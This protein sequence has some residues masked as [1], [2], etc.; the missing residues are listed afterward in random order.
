MLIKVLQCKSGGSCL[1]QFVSVFTPSQSPK[2]ARQVAG[3]KSKQE[4]ML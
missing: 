1:L 2:E 3:Q 4:K